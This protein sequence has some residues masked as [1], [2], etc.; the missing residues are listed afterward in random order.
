MVESRDKRETCRRVV[1]R[2][3]HKDLSNAFAWFTDAASRQAAE[4]LAEQ[5]KA[6]NRRKSDQVQIICIPTTKMRISTD[7]RKTGT[8]ELLAAFVCPCKP[9]RD[10]KQD[11]LVGAVVAGGRRATHLESDELHYG[12]RI[13]SVVWK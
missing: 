4:N 11:A 6:S 9:P 13:E 12:V 10:R 5:L 3:V 7:S 8:D 1:H 2:M